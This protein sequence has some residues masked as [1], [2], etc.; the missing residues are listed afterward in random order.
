M[1][2]MMLMGRQK[3]GGTSQQSGRGEDGFGHKARDAAGLKEGKEE[4]R[5][6]CHVRG[7]KNG[8]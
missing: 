4:S 1:M 5:T 7:D 8:E 6:E 3:I 2:L